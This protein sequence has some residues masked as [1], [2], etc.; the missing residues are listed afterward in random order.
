MDEFAELD[1]ALEAIDK[2]YKP[3]AQTAAMSRPQAKA[4]VGG[5]I[6]GRPIGSTL[7]MRDLDSRPV[8]APPQE[9]YGESPPPV[10]GRPDDEFGEHFEPTV[11]WS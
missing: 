5:G 9:T 7:H 10:P 2:Q 1:A 4:P 8:P 3:P 6:A 11:L